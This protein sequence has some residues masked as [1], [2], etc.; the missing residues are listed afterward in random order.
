MLSSVNTLSLEMYPMVAKVYVMYGPTVSNA[1]SIFAM[2]TFSQPRF[3][4]LV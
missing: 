2:E 4:A 1:M 3:R